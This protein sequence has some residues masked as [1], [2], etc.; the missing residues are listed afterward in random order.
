MAGGKLSPRQKMIN[1][2]YLVLTALLALNVSAEILEAFESLRESLAESAIEFADKNKD[3]K[4]G[5]V[6]KVD[7]EVQAGNTKNADVK[8]WVQFVE[9]Q[10]NGVINTINKDIDE[11]EKIGKLTPDGKIEQKSETEKNYQYWMGAGKD[12]ANGGRGAGAAIALSRRLNGYARWAGSFAVDTL[13][14]KREDLEIT[15]VIADTCD[16]PGCITSS[17]ASAQKK[18]KYSNQWEY[19]TF[20]SKPI[21]ADLALLEKFK[22]DVQNIHSDLLNLLKARLGAVTFKIDSLILVDAPYSRVVAA[23]MKFE[24]KLFVAATSESAV[25]RFGG[26]GSVQTTDGGFAAVMTMN[27]PGSFAKGQNEREIPYTATAVIKDAFGEDKELRLSSSYKVRKPEVVITSASVQN[28]YFK[29]GNIINV[30]VPALGDL[31][32]PVFTASSAQVLKSKSDKKK[33]TI[34]PSGKTCIL[35]V[36]S[37]TN[38]QTIKIDNIKYKVIKPPKP[39]IQLIVNGK[40][41]NGTSPINKK[42]KCI[43]RIKPDADFKSALPKDARY[44]VSKVV[45]KSQRSLGAPT[46][47]GSFSGNGKNAESGI[48][49]N[50]GSKLK[51]DPPGTKIYF[52]LDKIYRINF[53]QKRVEEKFGEIDLYIGAVIK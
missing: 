38:G 49:V 47:V 34:V 19:R 45:L 21:V 22:L 30:D 32:N 28:L 25:P 40:T 44:A 50:L 35:G 46:T 26:S 7:E 14:V 13:G 6:S 27:A 16:Y 33:I 9:S 41:Y 31:Y 39:Q 15:S 23:G 4:Q 1:M 43:V 48:T 42:S 29:C 3:T 5:I 11:L 37:N 24:T 51:S 36:S 8:R 52:K 18:S 17:E 2:M 10:T 20:H 12:Q 53:Q